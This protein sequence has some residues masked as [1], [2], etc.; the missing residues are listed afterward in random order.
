MFFVGFVLLR[1]QEYFRWYFCDFVEFK[2]SRSRK[3]EEK[4]SHCSAVIKIV[5]NFRKGETQRKRP[6]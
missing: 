4:C 1:E 5:S 3:E 6:K 2:E